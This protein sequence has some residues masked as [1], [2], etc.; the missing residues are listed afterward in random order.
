MGDRKEEIVQTALKLIADSGIEELTMKRIAT[1]IGITEPALYRHFAS[2]TEIL[3][4][5][6][7][8]MVTI[9][10]EMFQK[11]F[12]EG[13]TPAERISAFLTG[14]ATLF[15]E[16]P[17]MTV[18]LFSEEIFRT[19]RRF[20]IRIHAMMMDA[21]ERVE[22]EIEQGMKSGEFR[23]NLD[24]R[25]TALLLLGGFR[26]LVSTWYLGGK[27]FSLVDRTEEFVK[28]ALYLLERES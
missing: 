1:K 17:A 18:V 16:Q 7:E 6:V 13:R 3:A 26:L 5:L 24:A 22:K 10:Y 4:A 27:G 21:L 8:E 11:A 23:K 20:S 25:N 28:A 14:H 12:Q 15:Q 2:K 9:R 19:D